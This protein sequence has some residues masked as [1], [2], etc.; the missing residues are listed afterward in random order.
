MAHKFKLEGTGVKHAKR[1]MRDGVFVAMAQQLSNGKWGIYDP[2]DD[3]QLTPM[4][5]DSAGETR[6][7]AVARLKH[8]G[9][10]QPDADDIA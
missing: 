4:H 5:F 9:D 2:D 7:W 1:I 8:R 6:N 3:S 10:L